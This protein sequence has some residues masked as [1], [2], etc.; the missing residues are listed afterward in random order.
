MLHHIYFQVLFIYFHVSGLLACVCV[1]VY[2]HAQGSIWFWLLILF[3]FLC[4]GIAQV[5]LNSYSVDLA[6]QLDLTVEI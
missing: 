6:T 3:F 2:F 5:A 4:E 1:C